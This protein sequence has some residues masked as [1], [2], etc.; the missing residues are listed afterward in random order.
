MSLHANFERLPSFLINLECLDLAGQRDAFI[1]E[2]L[3]TG[4]H[5]SEPAEHVSHLWEA[6]LHEIFASGTSE[7]EVI[8][9]WKKAAH[10]H[11]PLIE[12]DGFITVHPQLTDTGA[13]Q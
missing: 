6:S 3:E 1:N 2:C 5:I 11:A 10:K 7:E 4:G 13:Q 12:A 9:N 8:R